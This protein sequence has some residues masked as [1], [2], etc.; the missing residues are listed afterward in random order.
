MVFPENNTAIMKF[1]RHD[2]LARMESPRSAQPQRN[3]VLRTG[4]DRR[5]AAVLNL[6]DASFCRSVHYGDLGGTLHHF[7]GHG[8]AGHGHSGG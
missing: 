1:S 3:L 8:H 5:D 4:C 2:V 7:H 6:N